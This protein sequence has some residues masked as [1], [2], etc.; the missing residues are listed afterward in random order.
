MK[1]IFIT[2]TILLYLGA[3]VSGIE[4]KTKALVNINFKNNEINHKY[5]STSK[6]IKFT[7]ISQ[8]KLPGS[9][10]AGAIFNGKNSKISFP[11]LHSSSQ[12]FHIRVKFSSLNGEQFLMGNEKSCVLQI[13]NKAAWGYLVKNIKIGHPSNQVLKPGVFYDIFWSFAIPQNGKNGLSRTFIFDVETG[14]LVTITKGWGTSVSATNI[15]PNRSFNIGP[16]NGVVDQVNVWGRALSFAEMKSLSKRPLANTF[17]VGIRR[18]A[19]SE[20]NRELYPFY[21][22]FEVNEKVMTFKD[23]GDSFKVNYKGLTKEHAFRGQRSFKLD[24]T[25]NKPG[26]YIWTF[27][28]PEIALK[29]TS[30]LGYMLVGKQSNVPVSLGYA[31]KLPPTKA[32]GCTKPGQAYFSTEDKWLKITSG[33]DFESNFERHGQSMVDLMFHKFAAGYISRKEIYPCMDSII[34]NVQAK[35]AGDRLVVYLDDI[36][37]ENKNPVFL[38]PK[39]AKSKA[40]INKRYDKTLKKFKPLI[41]QVKNAVASSNWTRKNIEL[42]NDIEAEVSLLQKLIKNFSDVESFQKILPVAAKLR[43]TLRNLN[44]LKSNDSSGIIVYVLHNITDKNYWILPFDKLIPGKISSKMVV[45]ACRGEYEPASF[46]IKAK[47]NIGSLSIKS[48]ALKYEG[49]AADL[50]PAKNVDIKYVKCWYQGASAGKAVVKQAGAAVLTPELLVNDPELVKVDFVKKKNYLRIFKNGKTSYKDISNPQNTEND[51]SAEKYPVYD[52]P[53][54]K[55]ISLKEGGNQQVWITVKVPWKITPGNYSGEIIISSN[56]KMLKR[57]VLQV[58]VPDF[59]LAKPY[60]T[61]SIDYH[62]TLGRKSSISSHGKS[63]KQMLAELKN[64]KAHGLDNCQ[65]YFMINEEDLTKVLKLRKLAGMKN[66]VLYLKGHG[67]NY[68]ATASDDLKEIQNRTKKIL[69][70]CRK[71]GAQTVYLY[72]RDELTGK[73]L[74]S[75][76]KAW[77]AMRKA[78]AKLFVAG[79]RDNLFLMGDIQ[80]MLVKAGWPDQNEVSGWHKYKHKIFCYFNPQVGVENPEY[81]RRGYGLVMWKFNYDGIANNAYQHSFGFTWNDFDHKKYR[82]HTFAYPTADGVVDTIAWEGYREAVDDVRYITTLENF[83]SEAAQNASVSK[84]DLNA[85]RRLVDDLRKSS[86]IEICDLDKLRQKI[87]KMILKLKSS[88]K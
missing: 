11:L 2:I 52:S 79:G 78:G 18:Q 87:I 28:M 68:F 4:L 72:G 60:Y 34:L 5:K 3:K 88:I 27:K 22:D 32:A 66:D 82:A 65:H 21:Q 38:S 84:N 63:E 64:M 30:L 81:Y 16:L 36:A 13:K 20:K 15:P 44:I 47:Q 43:Y 49:K 39:I 7:E 45:T 83:I 62:G 46:V 41:Y 70:I 58:K 14:K 77:Q 71:Y 12:T 54:L 40:I 74:A 25:F 17:P 35:K 10:G 42:K 33:K 73:K 69:D 59:E 19:L 8:F 76:R 61:A 67:M 80:D 29:G 51:F 1:R 9:N 23:Y 85:A 86:K 31:V 55:P 57:L 50:I 75:Q 24:V 26:R 48:T 6:N 37:L 56:G 53:V